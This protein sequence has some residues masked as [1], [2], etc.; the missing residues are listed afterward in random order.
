MTRLLSA[1]LRTPLGVTV[2][3]VVRRLCAGERAARHHHP[4]GLVATV[5]APPRA[6][7]HRK[8]LRRMGLHAVDVAA[9]A[10]AAA[11]AAG[12]TVAAGDRL[13]LFFGFGGLRAHWDDFMPALGAQR[14]DAAGA[15]ERGLKLLHPF[16]MLHHL[17]NAAHA[18]AAIDL[19]ARGEGVTFG[20]GNAGAQALVAAAAALDDGA[21]DTALVVATDSLVE[22]ET[23]VALAARG[24]ATR[25]PLEALA[26]PYD[27]DASGFVPGEAAAAIVVGRTGGIAHLAAACA[28]DG[29]TGEAAAAT[30]ASFARLGEAE[31][32]DGAALG[33]PD[34]DAAE[35]AALGGGGDDARPLCA[36]LAATGQI[37]AA[38]SLVQAIVLVEA[39]RRGVVPPIAGLRRP[40]PGPLRPLAVARP[41]SARNALAISAAAP[42]LAAALH[43]SL[44]PP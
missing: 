29:S 30:L 42:G 35:R 26:A 25:A 44:E 14:D 5:A 9:E 43:V 11:R 39:L 18:L 15:W 38:A 6:S 22:P 20:G 17:S 34:A 7:K 2:D 27:V 40:A 12:E 10:L 21:I 24:A 1:A 8:F 32:V 36:T 19:D 28:A 23:L 3:E 37:G 16:W 4:A 33:R 41:T 13:G 31:I